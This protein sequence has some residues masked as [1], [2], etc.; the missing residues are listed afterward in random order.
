MEAQEVVLAEAQEVVI[1]VT[2]LD[3]VNQVALGLMSH[4]TAHKGL[5]RSLKGLL[6]A[7]LSLDDI[8]PIFFGAIH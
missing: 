2:C 5:E 4:E 3:V 1:I 7:L 6:S 8:V